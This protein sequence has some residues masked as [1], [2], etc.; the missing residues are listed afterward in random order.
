MPGPKIDKSYIQGKNLPLSNVFSCCQY[1]SLLR[2]SS[3]LSPNADLQ[4][5]KQLVR[6]LLKV[7][8]IH[9]GVIR[10]CI[11]D[12]F[13]FDAEKQV[14]GANASIR[15]ERYKQQILAIISPVLQIFFENFIAGRRKS[16][17]MTE[18]KGFQRLLPCLR[19]SKQLFPI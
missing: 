13:A 2:G 3:T 19:A 14:F 15:Y 1:I 11:H 18:M 6:D 5:A 9:G 12:A 17:P 7:D 10:L 4:R 8:L 16:S